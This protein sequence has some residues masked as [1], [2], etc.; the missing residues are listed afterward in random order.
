MEFNLKKIANELNKKM[1]E[2]ELSLVK[3]IVISGSEVI[4]P[5]MGFFLNAGNSIISKFNEINLKYLLLGLSINLDMEKKINQLY[6]YAKS[7]SKKAYQLANVLKE[8]IVS[9]S[10]KSCVIMGLVL[11]KNIDEAKDFSREDL[12]VCRAL[13]NATD[14]DLENFYEIMKNHVETIIDGTIKI[15]FN[16]QDSDNIYDYNMTCKWAVYNRLFSERVLEWAGFPVS[17]ETIENE[18]SNFYVDKPAEVLFDL[19]RKAQQILKYN[20][21]NETR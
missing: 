19:I 9:K 1:N 18:Y 3:D 12:I 15:V 5:V 16:S 14:Y 2:P 11:A 6:D 4:D 20:N 17:E 7:D 13:E 21:K 8:T 10:P